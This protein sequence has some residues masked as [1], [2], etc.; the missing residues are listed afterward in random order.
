MK[1]D[2]SVER[3]AH[4]RMVLGKLIM[5][6]VSYSS[7]KQYGCECRMLLTNAAGDWFR[8]TIRKKN[9]RVDTLDLEK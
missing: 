9:P 3:T 6:V 4:C 7:T 8:M 5:T 2:S 1:R